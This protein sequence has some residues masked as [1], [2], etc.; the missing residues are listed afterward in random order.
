M[1]NRFV[2]SGLAVVLTLGMM[3]VSAAQAPTTPQPS[4]PVTKLDSTDREFLNDA[5]HS[6]ALEIQ[7]SKVA[8]EKGR[9]ADVKAFAQKMIDEHTKVAQKLSELAKSKGYEIPSDPSMMQKAKLKML[10]VRDDS[11]DEAYAKEIGVSAHE[12]AVKLFEKAS[13][14]AQD[15][16]VKQFATETL[17]SLK[18]HLEEARKLQQT[19]APAKQ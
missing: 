5:A 2:N 17:P 16:D 3:G 10:D 4:Q 8:L 13:S 14:E 7:A 19:V 11:F 18:H 6:G 12:D 9:H 1:M 15:P